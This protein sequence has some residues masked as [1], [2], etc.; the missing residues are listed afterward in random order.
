VKLSDGIRTDFYDSA[1][2]TYNINTGAVQNISRDFLGPF[3]RLT[4]T[5]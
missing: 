4:G 1:L 5:F 2:T 3:L